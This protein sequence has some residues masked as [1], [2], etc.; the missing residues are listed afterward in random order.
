MAC[1]T[2]QG[3]E[4]DLLG[5]TKKEVV[6]IQE[7]NAKTQQNIQKLTGLGKKG[8]HFHPP[9]TIFLQSV[10]CMCPFLASS[11]S[12]HLVTMT[13]SPMWQEPLEPRPMSLPSK[14]LINPLWTV[15]CKIIIAIVDDPLK[16]FGIATDGI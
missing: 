12:P 10:W 8:L 14:P 9:T 2:S 5:V 16:I 6:V 1:K 13:I 3:R 7:N 15:C 11:V 4:L